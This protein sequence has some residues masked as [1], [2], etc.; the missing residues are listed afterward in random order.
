[1]QGRAMGMMGMMG[2]GGMMAMMGMGEHIEG[3]IAFLRAELKI[4]DAQLPQWNAFADALRA[5]AK[6]MSGMRNTMMQ[7]M[8]QG[9]TSA[10]APARLDRMEKMMTA[11]LDAVKTTKA[12]LGP[13]YA[14]LSDDQKKVADELIQGP[15]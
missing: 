9:G 3:R 10:S 12:A 8:S 7:N 4:T 11:M 2:Q 6:R 15:M 5:N 13:L 14:A 1:M